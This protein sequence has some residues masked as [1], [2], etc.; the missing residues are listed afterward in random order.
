MEQLEKKLREQ[1]E[2]TCALQEL[3]QLFENLEIQDIGRSRNGGRFHKPKPNRSYYWPQEPASVLEKGLL[4]SFVEMPTAGVLAPQPNIPSITLTVPDSEPSA[5]AF[6]KAINSSLLS[7]AYARQIPST[8][9]PKSS[10]SYRKPKAKIRRT[11]K[12]APKPS[13]FSYDICDHPRCP[14][15][16]YTHEKGVFRY[17]EK[18]ITD[19]EHASA[20]II[21]GT[22]N[23]TPCVWDAYL[24]A[25]DNLKA[26]EAVSVEDNE[27]VRGFVA[28]HPK[29]RSGRKEDFKVT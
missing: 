7:P 3:Q 15:K 8:I 17:P 9:Q 23:P 24:R 20:N 26:M 12:L 25:L 29:P 4:V 21:F 18:Y 11:Q 5:H 13:L 10:K 28:A 27:I 19:E 16:S 14:I 1:K 2:E 22:G 6:P